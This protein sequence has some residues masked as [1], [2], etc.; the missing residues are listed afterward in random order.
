MFFKIGIFKILQYSQENTYVGVNFF[1]KLQT[2]RYVTLL[3]R[4]SNTGVSLWVMRNF[5]NRFFI[6][7]PLVAAS[8]LPQLSKENWWLLLNITIKKNIFL[9]FLFILKFSLQVSC[10][11]LSLLWEKPISDN[12][13]YWAT[14]VLKYIN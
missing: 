11:E 12:S 2:W 13:E 1:I 5:K 3:K 7:H 10:H 14:D 6:E 4:D 8:T 9:F